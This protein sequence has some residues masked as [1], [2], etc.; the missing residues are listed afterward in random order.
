MRIAP[1]AG[2]T[3]PSLSGRCERS[4]VVGQHPVGRVLPA[5]SYAAMRLRDRRGRVSPPVPVPSGTTGVASHRFMI[6]A[7]GRAIAA[8]SQPQAS[9]PLAIEY[10]H[11]DSLGSLQA[12]TASDASVVETR[13]FDAFGGAWGSPASSAQVPYGYTGQEQDS[14][15]GQSTCVAGSTTHPS[16]SSRPLIQSSIVFDLRPHE[17]STSRQ[18]REPP[19]RLLG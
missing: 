14:E 9:G 10:L 11:D 6:Y 15:L 1:Q 4:L 5:V 7:G 3:G 13:H 17:Q 8:V 19:L 16:A 12:T 18:S 2:F